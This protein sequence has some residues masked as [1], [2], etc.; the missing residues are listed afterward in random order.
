M[1]LAELKSCIASV[2]RTVGRLEREKSLT[3]VRIVKLERR[4]EQVDAAIRHLVDGD[5]R[6]ERRRVARAS[7]KRGAQKAGKRRGGLGDLVFAAVGRGP[8]TCEELTKKAKAA[9]FSGAPNAVPAAV[10]HD[11]RLKRLKD[12]RVAKA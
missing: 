1:N 9:G 11:A 10:A 5:G 12:G 2:Q 8:K 6:V 4:R 7:A 3:S